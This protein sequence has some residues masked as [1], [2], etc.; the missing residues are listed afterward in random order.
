MSD[1]IK[2]LDYLSRN[3]QLYFDG[4]TRYKS[5]FGGVISILLTLIGGACLIYMFTKIVNREEPVVYENRIFRNSSSYTLNTSE[6]VIAFALVDKGGNEMDDT[7][8]SVYA[9]MFYYKLSPVELGSKKL[10]LKGENRTIKISKCG[11]D[12]K[13]N[14]SEFDILYSSF[15][16]S[17]YYCL[18]P[19]QIIKI[20]NPF[21]FSNDFSYLN[22]FFTRCNDKPDCKNSTVSDDVLSS[23]YVGLISTKYHADNQ[24][25]DQPLKPYSFRFTELSSSTVF[26]RIYYDLKNLNYASDNGLFLTDKVLYN[27][28]TFDKTRISSDFGYKEYNN[29]KLYLQLTFSFSPEGFHDDY[30][31]NYLKVP[32]MLA[33]VGGFLNIL[34]I[35]CSISLCIFYEVSFVSTIFSQYLI[36]INEDANVGEK[37]VSSRGRNLILENLDNSEKFNL[38]FTN[39]NQ[40]DIENLDKINYTNSKKEGDF[41][42]EPTPPKFNQSNI[43]FSDCVGSMKNSNLKANRNSFPVTLKYLHTMRKNQNKS[44]NPL[45]T[46]NQISIN[47]IKCE[48]LFISPT[49]GCQDNSAQLLHTDNNLCY[50][51]NKKAEVSINI[52]NSRF[53]LKFS[54][55]PS[56]KYI[57]FNFFFK[58]FKSNSKKRDLFYN[59]AKEKLIKYYLNINSLIDI[60]NEINFLKKSF[61]IENSMQE[62]CTYAQKIISLK[63]NKIY[64]NEVIDLDTKRH[65]E[66][67][68]ENLHEDVREIM[69]GY[70]GS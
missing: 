32:S 57:V 37:K 14:S 59:L 53:K 60:R 67:R 70:L 40:M 64:N 27:K 55:L 31:R 19:G 26:K 4:S 38:N 41:F 20:E 36:Y 66:E 22:L 45:K 33:Y 56:R 58:C 68:S 52:P 62:I 16:F 30:Y 5:T 50:R 17:N 10:V 43:K 48:N 34:K 1:K 13:L 54:D 12:Y 44:L 24:N 51:E 42:K 65:M 69:L 21:G 11:R 61:L 47:K 49:P 6:N 35:I 3:T 15:D 9:S 23:Y 8:F 25:F 29:A 7:I 18:D 39:K 46:S 28:T 63:I 2:H